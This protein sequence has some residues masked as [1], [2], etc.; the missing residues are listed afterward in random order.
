MDGNV[1][2]GGLSAG[3]GGSIASPGASDPVIPKLTGN[4]PDWTNG[5]ITYMGLSGIQ[6]AAGA[7]PANAT[8]PMLVYWHGTGSTSNEYTSM[9]APVADGIL[10]GGGVIVSFQGTTG[11]DLY[12]GTSIF[13]QGDLKI[14][15][16]LVACAVR[17][18]NVDPRRIY[19]MGCSAG[20][21]FSTAMAALRSSY[22]A[23]AAPNSGGI[24]MAPPFDSDHVPP[25]MTVHG[26]MGTDVVI[27]DFAA[28]SG[29][30]DK[31]FKQK[32]GFVVDCNTGG[33]HCSGAA[34]AGD[35]WTFFQAHT[36]GVG[37]EPW[38]T[39]LPPGFSNQCQIQ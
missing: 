16:Q 35:V 29:S 7:R 12:S 22:I 4:C 17:D 1:G 38:K 37:P 8:A 6:I 18:H 36:Y 3:D 24:V 5:T 19:T 28:A 10:A 31:L 14:V 34:L 23:A 39:G 13:G 26:A 9:A 30:A 20:A 33:G 27:V 32:G 2:T 25:L 15:D 11:G 21:L